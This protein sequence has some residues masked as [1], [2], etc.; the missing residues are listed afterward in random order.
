MLAIDNLKEKFELY[1]Y[2]ADQSIFY[3]QPTNDKG[4]AILVTDVIQLW[5][6]LI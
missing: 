1:G 2:A 4:K 5:W 6:D 3:M